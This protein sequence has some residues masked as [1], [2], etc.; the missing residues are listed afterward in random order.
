MLSYNYKESKKDW[1]SN[2]R[3]NLQTKITLL[4]S[5]FSA[6]SILINLCCQMLSISLY[7]GA[8]SIEISIAAG[9][10]FGFPVRYILEKHYI[11]KFQSKNIQHDGMLFLLYSIL[12]IFT[13]TIF[14]TIE[15]GFHLI[16]SN[17]MLRYLGGAIGL[18]L[19]CIVKY[20]LDKKY[21]FK[22][23]QAI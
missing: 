13:T 1:G 19:G 5:L 20:H 15:Y 3:I 6:L 23:L 18:V 9:I 17:D 4:Y 8:Y 14:L 11:F 12:S 10:I 7:K 22:S 2:M 21:V 16:F